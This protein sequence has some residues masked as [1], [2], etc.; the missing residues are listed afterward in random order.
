M[1]A[2]QRRR[3][4]SGA[5]L[6]WY[7]IGQESKKACVV[8]EQG[9]SRLTAEALE[10][11]GLCVEWLELEMLDMTAMPK[12]LDEEDTGTASRKGISDGYDIIIAVDIIEYAHNPVT[13]LKS[14]HNL[15]KPDGRFLL[16]ADNRLGIRYF[17]GDQDAFSGKVYGSVE[18]YVH[19]FPR[20]REEMKGR[21]YSKA[22]L[23]K[24]LEEAGFRQR[25]VFSVFPRISNPQLLLAED[26][27]PN[28]SLD[29]RIFPE[30]NNPDTVFL[31]EEELYPSLLANGLLH[32]MAN[33]FFIECAPEDSLSPVNQVTLSGERGV[34]NAMATILRRDGLV[35]KRA[36]YQPGRM[37][38][39]QLS[40]NNEYLSAHRVRMIPGELYQEAFVMPY[41]TGMPANDYFRELLKHDKAAFL[42]QLDAFRDIL[43]HS[44]EH[45]AAD[46]V[47]WEQFEPGW[48]KRK[49][50]DP[51]RDKWKKIAFGSREER[52][53][54]GVIV[55]RGYLDL[56]SLNCFYY[57]NQFV[58]YDQELFLENVPV[59]AILL[60]TIEFIY[61]FNDQLDTILPRRELFERYGLLKH[62]EL[63]Q[64]FITSFL[65]I[66]RDDD[67]LSD[68]YK[69][70]R[71]EAGIVQ[72]NRKR[73]N[74]SEEE[75]PMIFKDIFQHIK[76]RRL[77]LF[78]SGRYAK[79]FREKYD[80]AYPV[81]GYL[82]NDASRWG[83]EI[84]GL[85][86]LAP[87]A[88]KEMNPAEYKV[89]ICIRDYMP[90]VKQL[91]R[92]NISNFSVYDPYIFYRDSGWSGQEQGNSLVQSRE[93][94]SPVQLPEIPKYNIGYVAG[95]FD[96]FHIGHLNL[97]RRAKEQCNYLIV[98]VVTDEG[99]IRHKKSMPRIPFE[100][101]IAI[102]RACR[103]VDEAVEIPVDKGDTDEA[104]HRYRFDVQFS[105]SDYAD[106]PKWLAK[107][108]FLQRHGADLV[109][110]PYTEGISTT[111]LKDME[112]H[113]ESQENINV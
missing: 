43:L 71:R 96:L 84:D 97:L 89:M 92:E 29:I 113:V 85:P 46:E 103:Y 40:D 18:N 35:E 62:M 5:I 58:F 88:L 55:K 39:R 6:K 110:F 34:E 104:Y 52:E 112:K 76:G 31:F 28:E 68:Y 19:L 57:E 21:A 73:M 90:V 30:Y 111:Q 101:R 107:K 64:K 63:F 59:K 109:F 91:K 14:I 4:L 74:Y 8:C 25:R 16:A 24:F 102:V 75:Y 77:Y 93:K 95:V 48:E 65:N 72:E 80:E 81:S 54:L 94:S 22:E 106:D 98:G 86:V 10:E 53:E 3:K 37:K 20:E 13:V 1:T 42:K 87:A 47:N 23:V 78:G 49:K 50:D 105:G 69:E 32:G 9:N 56:V 12:L 61:K 36:L 26:Y 51:N 45:A 67:G 38:L 33:G 83:T 11:E 2:E 17:C 41:V 44:S 66:L 15:L 100:E 99:V 79:R 82:D 27:V 108:D 7:D 60:R 70:G